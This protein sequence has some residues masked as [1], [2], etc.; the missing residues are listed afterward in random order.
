M[1][2]CR[3]PPGQRRSSARQLQLTASQRRIG[4]ANESLG[5]L[6]S[7]SLLDA[8]VRVVHRG[9]VAGSYLSEIASR[10]QIIEI[11]LLGIKLAQ[12][13]LK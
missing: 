3:C 11:E 9:S 6:Y 13:Y 7:L 5:V 8:T 4:E 10:Q 12:S 1:E 2:R